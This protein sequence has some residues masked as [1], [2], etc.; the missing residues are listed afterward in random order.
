MPN[1]P[2][3]TILREYA[4]EVAARVHPKSFSTGLKNTPKLYRVPPAITKIRKETRMI[5]CP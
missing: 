3:R 4:P 5:I 1:N 2:V